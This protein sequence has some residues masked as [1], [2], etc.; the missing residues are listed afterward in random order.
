MTTQII[1]QRFYNDYLPE[2]SIEAFQRAVE[3]GAD[4]VLLHIHLTRDL[5][6]MVHY[7]V[8]LEDV[9]LPNRPIYDC[10]SEE[11]KSL[12]LT[13]HQGAVVGDHH[14]HRLYEVLGTLGRKTHF[15][16]EIRTPQPEVV[17][18]LSE[19]L[20]DFRYLWHTLEI[21]SPEPLILRAI[22]E[23]C[24]ELN[25]HLILPRQEAW[26]EERTLPYYAIQRA[27]LANVTTLHLHP[28][29]LTAEVVRALAQEGIGVHAWDVNRLFELEA[30]KEWGITRF[31]TEQLKT[32]LTYRT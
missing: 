18:I 16:L 31:S 14:V 24:P 7:G 8:Y 23:H 28:S 22:Q 21:T 5:I 17:A 26:A 3:M 29:Q 12:P 2:N 32:A 6:P 4:G 20:R 30:I 13:N 11:L 19:L 27:R 10:A 25:T 15:E 9:G 1:A